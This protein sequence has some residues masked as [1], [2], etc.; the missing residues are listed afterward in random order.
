MEER[1]SK[2]QWLGESLPRTIRRDACMRLVAV[3]ARLPAVNQ[4]EEIGQPLTEDLIVG[5]GWTPCLLASNADASYSV[6]CQRV[7]KDC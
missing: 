6:N 5:T 7:G 4:M 3:L 2:H 1:C